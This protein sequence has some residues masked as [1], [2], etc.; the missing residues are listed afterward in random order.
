MFCVKR[1][2][3]FTYAVYWHELSTVRAGTGYGLKQVT[4]ADAAEEGV[5]FSVL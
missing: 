2:Q 1:W 5:L 3:T 4:T